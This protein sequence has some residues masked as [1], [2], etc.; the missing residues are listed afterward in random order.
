MLEVLAG[1]HL[2][3]EFRSN[4][5]EELVEARGAIAG[6]D[7]THPAVGG[8]HRHGGLCA[9]LRGRMVKAATR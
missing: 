8:I 2:A 3:L 9:T 4:L 7:T 5:V 6:R 1:S